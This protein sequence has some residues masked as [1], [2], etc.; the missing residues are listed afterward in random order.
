MQLSWS[1][2]GYMGE[3]L[4]VGRESHTRTRAASKYE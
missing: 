1:L 4:A 2:D 3:C